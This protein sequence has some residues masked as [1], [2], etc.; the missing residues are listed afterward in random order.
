MSVIARFEVIPI[1][2]G[3]MS[4]AI[5]EA[6]RALDRH[7]VSYR[8]TPTDTIIEADT[9]DQVFAAVRDAHQAIPDERVITSVEVDEDRRRPQNMGERVASVEREL[10]HPPQRSQQP[11]Q[12]QPAQVQPTT[13]QAQPTPSQS[14][15]VQSQ[16]A[17]PQSQPQQP[18]ATSATRTQSRQSDVGPLTEMGRPGQP[19]SSNR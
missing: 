2:E 10:G 12:S 18:G 19:T 13:Q 8:T 1:Q 5:A 3:S 11:P 7:P 9:V 4:T 17:S 14:Q 15:P 6:L 16:S